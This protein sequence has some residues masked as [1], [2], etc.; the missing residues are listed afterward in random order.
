LIAI[1]FI[2]YRIL[3]PKNTVSVLTARHCETTGT[4]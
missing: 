4:Q 1:S 2:I 3:A